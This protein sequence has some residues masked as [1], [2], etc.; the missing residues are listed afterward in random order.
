[1]AFDIPSKYVPIRY[2]NAWRNVKGRYD[3]MM[4]LCKWDTDYRKDLIITILAYILF[5]YS[6][7]TWNTIYDVIAMAVEASII[8]V[9][10]GG[11]MSILPADYRPS[12]GGVRYSVQSSTHIAYDELSFLMS[13]VYPAEKE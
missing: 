2:V 6:L 7:C 11:E 13:G 4:F 5:I 8:A 3:L 12:H 10:V 9:Q 1:M